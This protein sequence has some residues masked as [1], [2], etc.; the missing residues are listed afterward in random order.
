LTSQIRPTA[1][2]VDLSALQR[3][4]GRVRAHLG[5]AAV[6][7]AVKADAYGHGAVPAARALQQAGCDWFGVALVEEGRAL[8]E[9]GIE[10]PI[11]LLSGVGRTGARVA[12]AHRLTPVVYDLDTAS[13]LAAV[14]LERGER[15][16]VHVKV[17]TGMGRLGVP[18]REW[19]GFL[20][21]LATLPALDVEGI[22]SH[23]AS[24]DADPA[25]TRL[26]QQRFDDAVATARRRGLAPRYLH[27]ANSPGLLT[28]V[29]AHYHLVR[30]GLL[31]YGVAPAPGMA[32]T[33]GL[34][35]VMRVRTEVLFVKD[36]PPG[37]A[38]SYGRTWAAARPSRIATLPVGYADGY[39][40]LL[41]NRA[42][43][44][45]HGR[46]APV[47]GNVCMDLTMVDVTD[48]DVP[49]RAG[50]EVVLLGRQGADVLSAEELAVSAGTIPYAIL[51]GF[52]ERVPR[53]HAGGQA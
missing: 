13:A 18:W 8:R 15:F 42:S 32:D 3:N 43:V 50:D 4:L 1:A 26:Q 19:A 25:F 39:S 53:R 2:E 17:D 21:R 36:L 40:R 14:A 7:A 6:L 31:L 44:L 49:V 47:R 27:L 38:V 5:S 37:E 11:L 35:P 33:L 10:R 12:V 48:V 9:A 34:E 45:V 52:S 51:C 20:E 29:E 28:R 23:F 46:R 22:L 30:P 16:S 24:A 41:S